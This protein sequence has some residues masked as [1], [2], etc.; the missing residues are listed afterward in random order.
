MSSAAVCIAFNCQEG[1]AKGSPLCPTHKRK[2]T[3][4]CYHCDTEY[5]VPGWICCAKC[6]TKD[7]APQLV[8]KIGGFRS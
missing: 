8:R 1:R 5:A 2:R 6:A 4:P 7:R 3:P